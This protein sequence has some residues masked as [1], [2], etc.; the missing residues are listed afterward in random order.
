MRIFPARMSFLK[1][2]LGEWFNNYRF[3]MLDWIQV[4]VSSYCNA[5][6]AYCPHAIYRENWNSRHL[7]LATF[8]KLIPVFGRIKMVFLQGWGEPLLNPAFFEMVGRA[9]KCGCVVGTTTNG[10]LLD[11]VNIDRILSSGLDILA[12]SLAGT[13]EKNDAIRAGT[14]I[15]SIVKSIELLNKK[16]EALGTEKPAVHLAYLLLRSRMADLENLADF[17]RGLGIDQVVVSTLDFIADDAFKDEST[18]ACDR[19][20][21][22]AIESKLKNLKNYAGQSK[23]DIHYQV[24]DPRRKG[25][26]CSE[27]IRGSMFISADGSVSPCVFTNIPVN[28][29]SYI[30][31]DVEYLYQRLFFGDV[32]DRSPA[33]I[34]FSPDYVSFRNSFLTGDLNIICQN[35]G[36]M[37]I[38]HTHLETG[39]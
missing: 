2:R 9:K 35:C 18:M 7:P 15:N 37:H 39:G 24:S 30:R 19:R 16:K 13:D 23:T 21:M 6:C 4:E 3:P 38:L 14:N 12:V 1:N 34:W 36:K 32:N 22:E 20:E 17:A 11:E 31:N 33:S 28:D 25:S 27:N 5:S 26:I 8:E 29:V 10:M